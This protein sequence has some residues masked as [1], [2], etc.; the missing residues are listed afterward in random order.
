ML[1]PDP[2]ITNA[3]PKHWF[4]MHNTAIFRSEELQRHIATTGHVD[5]QLVRV[6]AGAADAFKLR[7]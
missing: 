1:D 2:H 6:V 7:Y 5:S 4:G 3:D